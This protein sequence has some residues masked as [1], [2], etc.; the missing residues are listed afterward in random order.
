MCRRHHHRRRRAAAFYRPPSVLCVA[1]LVSVD[2]DHSIRT[3]GGAGVPE[4][5]VE[6]PPRFVRTDPPLHR[7]ASGD[8]RGGSLA[9]PGRPGDPGGP[10][11]E[12]E[13][14]EERAVLSND[15]VG[16][17]GRR[18]GGTVPFPP[19]KREPRLFRHPPGHGS[20][21]REPRRRRTPR[22][23]PRRAVIVVVVSADAASPE[24][25]VSYAFPHE[26]PPHVF[27]VFFLRVVAAV[28][29]SGFVTI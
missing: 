1:P 5:P 8:K 25:A 26:A 12:G 20:S 27:L 3:F 24:H 21:N 29:S 13:E 6:G 28:E 17:R 4:I 15:G 9:R 2:S 19:A 16:W 10:S 7:C 22:S 14:T 11:T 18:I 23:S